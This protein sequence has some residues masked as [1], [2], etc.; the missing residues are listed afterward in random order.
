MVCILKNRTTV[1]LLLGLLVI[2]L[3][4]SAQLKSEGLI[5]SEV[6]LD[7]SEPSRSWIEIYNPTSLTQTLEK[8][9]SYNVL[10][11]NILPE[12]VKKNGGIEIGSGESVILC[13]DKNR[14]NF[15]SEKDVI[16]VNEII[17]FGKGGFFSMRTKGMSQNGVDIFRYG[18]PEKTDELKDQIGDFV[19]P[20]SK[21]GKSH[22]RTSNQI[23]K[24][25]MRPVFIETEPS[26]GF[27]F[28]KE[29]SDE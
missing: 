4:L 3:P 29:S 9:R 21:N 24:E 28:E 1:M 7:E 8:F 16:Q 19:V 23:Q 18:Y 22:T 11:T 13:A 26:P 25:E 20:F 2:T 5:F 27:Y 15:N 17:H 6:Y 12:E 10:T 14:I